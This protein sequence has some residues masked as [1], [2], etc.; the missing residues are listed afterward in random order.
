MRTKSTF[1][2][3]LLLL[4]LLV[5]T[6]GSFGCGDDNLRAQASQS[7]ALAAQ[8]QTVLDNNPPGTL[9]DSELARAI[10]NVLPVD[11]QRSFQNGVTFLGDA[12]AAGYAVIPE[13]NA[14][15]DR[16]EEQADRDATDG[17]NAIV[18]GLSLVELILTGT[19]GLAG[20]LAT[21]FGIGKVRER[22]AKEDEQAIT[23]DLVSSIE[24]SPKMKAAIKDGGGAELGMS[25]LTQTQKRVAEIKKSIKSSSD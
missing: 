22:R 25:Q 18:A 24:R 23:E 17:Q 14:H 5:F 3:T 21:I 19:T 10:G 1:T 9:E 4:L 16:L 6:L 15:A 11:W 20:S 2:L 13:L 12:R 7:R 8:V